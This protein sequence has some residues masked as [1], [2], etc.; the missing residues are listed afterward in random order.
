MEPPE[1]T[2][3][4]TT[5]L[6][7]KTG[8]CSDKQQPHRTV[9]KY[10]SS[11]LVHGLNTLRMQRRRFDLVSEVFDLHLPELRS[12]KTK[13]V[14]PATFPRHCL[15]RLI[16]SLPVRNLERLSSVFVFRRF[17]CL[18]GCPF[19]L[20]ECPQAVPAC[21]RNRRF[22]FVQR[23]P[24]VPVWTK[25]TVTSFSHSPGDS[26]GTCLDKIYRHLFLSFSWGF[27]RYLSGQNLPSS[28]SLILLGIPKGPVWTKLTVTSFSHS[29]GDSQG[30]RLDNIYRHLF[31]SF[32]WGFPRDPSGQNLPSPLSIILLGIPKV[33]VWTKFTVTYFSHVPGD[34]QGTC[35]DKLTVTSFS[36]SPGDSQGTCL[37][38]TYRHL[39]LSFSWGFP[40]Y[41]SG[42]N[43]PSPL[44]LMFLGIP[45][46]P[47]W[48]K[49]TVTLFLSFSWGF[50]RDPSG[51]NFPS[52]IS[53]MF[54][55]IPKVPV[56]TKFTVT[57]FS[58]SPG[59]CQ[60]TRLDN[61]PSPLSLILLGIPKGPVWRKFTV[62]SFSH[63][64][65]DSQVTRLDK[66]YRQ[67]FLSF[68][69][70]FPR[71][72]SGQNLPSPLSLILL[73]IPKVPVWTK[74][75]V[76]SFSHSPGDS[77]RTRLDKI[78][79]HLFLSCS[80]G[81][82]RDPSGQNL[83]SL[84]SLI[85][86]EIPKGPV[87]TKTYRHLFRSSS[88]G[89]PRDPSG[90]NLPSL[91]S[92]MFL[93]IPKGP[94]WTKFTVTSFSHSPGDSQGTRLDKFLPSPLSLILLGIPKGPVWTKFTVTYFSC[95]WGFPRDLSGQNL[96][97]LFTGFF[98]VFR[99]FFFSCFLM[100]LNLC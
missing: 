9:S 73:G 90:Q 6:L 76:T 19:C 8:R 57:S 44:S 41:P 75:T 24:K 69:W 7:Q 91:I 18:I 83:P 11:H 64:P 39:F 17:I 46:G 94:V 65:G 54:L 35:L 53:L 100:V 23:I 61:L 37:D 70:R 92:L 95:S 2:D 80:W 58:H 81:F 5:S 32:S 16:P 14:C 29:P 74:F 21:P 86:L 63:V 33:P 79:R 68:S 25:F 26:Q 4:P 60:G 72:P 30:T 98:F 34:S 15:F 40:R 62:T 12:T 87:W 13:Y 48:T 59:D 71:Y 96:P 88:W 3:R 49:F 51:Q 99:C 36:H 66:I 10:K 43:L 89:F 85:I 93:G 78:Y 38:K 52:L 28:L 67:F 1:N 22:S 50:P 55:G 31:L 82:P 56:W 20:I 47:V 42:Q 84:L 45:K 77:Q 27:P 97:S